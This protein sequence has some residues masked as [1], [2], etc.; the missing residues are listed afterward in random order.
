MKHRIVLVGPGRLGQALACLLA[1]A[2]HTISAIIGRDAGRAL[3][4]SR[5][6]GGRD[7]GT[8]DLSRARQGDV[9]LLT[10]PDDRLAEMARTLRQNGWLTPEA[11]VIHCSGRHRA[12]LLNEG[13][14][15]KVRALSL[16]PLQTFADAVAGIRNLP[17]S[18]FSVEGEEALLPLGESLVRDL[19]GIPFRIRGE[20]KTLYHAAAC[21]ASN[22][23]VTLAD[24]AG[25]IMAACGFSEDEAI[26]LLIPLLKGTGLNL[27][28]LGPRRAL[29]GPIARGDAQT[30][31]AHLRALSVLPEELRDIYRV[32]GRETVTLAVRKGT[33]NEDQAKVIRQLLADRTNP[34]EKESRAPDEN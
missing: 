31:A 29:T 11:V 28:T 25:Q 5:F 3:T 14:G 26:R 18:Y 27:V 13:P 7:A 19:G 4:A 32:M 23:L 20:Q 30:L 24:A 8:T 17:G 21:V 9:V 33:L 10:L 2:G 1:E 6:I 15:P 12:A 16:H 34:D 22:Y